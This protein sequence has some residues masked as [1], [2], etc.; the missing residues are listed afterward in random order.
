MDIEEYT[1]N[2]NRFAKAY[3]LKTKDWEPEQF[4]EHLEEIYQWAESYGLKVDREKTGKIYSPIDME[5]GYTKL[6]SDWEEPYYVSKGNWLYEKEGNCGKGYLCVD[7]GADRPSLDKMNSN[8][9]VNVGQVCDGSREHKPRTNKTPFLAF[10][11]TSKKSLNLE[12][13]KKVCTVAKQVSV[14]DY[15]KQDIID[16]CTDSYASEKDTKATRKWEK[17]YYK[18]QKN[19]HGEPIVVGQYPSVAIIGKK[20]NTKQFWEVSADAISE[21][22]DIGMGRPSRNIAIKKSKSKSQKKH[23]EFSFG[24]GF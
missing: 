1:K 12:K 10:D 16:L 18:G 7:V 13:L 4:K 9:A 24:E 22:E 19:L 15:G 11:Y 21:L 6:C 17:E 5:R 20:Y 2:Y 3:K 14:S 23:S 8:P